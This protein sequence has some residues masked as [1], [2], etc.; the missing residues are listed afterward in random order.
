MTTAATPGPELR[1]RWNYPTS[2]RFGAGRVSELPAA[3]R[4]LG[5]ERPLLV[6]DAGLARL[7][8]VGRA[9][10]LC[11]DAGLGCE[12][13]SEVQ[14]NPVEANVTQGV[15]RF[16]AG[17]HDGVIAFGGGSALDTGKAIGLMVG[18][19]RPIWDFEDRDDWYTRVNVAGMAPV[20]AVPTTAGTGSEVGR[21]SVLTDLRDHT[22]RL[23]FHPRILPAIVIEDPELGV[24]LPANVTAA[25]GMDAL[26]HNLEAYCAP[27]YHPMADGIAV[28]GMRLIKEWLPAVCRDGADLDARA[29]MLIASTMGA[30]AFQKGLGAMHSLSHPCSANL[31][32]HHGLTNGVVMPYVLM[33]NEPAIAHKLARLAAYLGLRKATYSG[34]VDWVLELREII[35]IPAALSALGVKEEHAARFAPQALADPST[36]S[37]PV[38]M[39]R[40]AFERLYLHAIRGEL[41]A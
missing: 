10:A 28:E 14:P 26:S 34:F 6:T 20:V 18:Q 19:T 17:G 21:C 25:V 22:K 5:S 27:S 32:T 8:I 40:A 4:E 39:D 9:V 16:R 29:H 35:G 7:P 1:G 30:T 33:H 38:P 3:C 24:G 41:T 15:D 11:R 37:N 31:N 2:I 23:I 12:V 13:F 36:P